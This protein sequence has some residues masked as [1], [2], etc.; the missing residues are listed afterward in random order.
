MKHS[1]EHKLQARVIA[2]VVDLTARDVCATGDAE[3]NRPHNV[4]ARPR[5]G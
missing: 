4:G 3:C 5:S 2:A 1:F